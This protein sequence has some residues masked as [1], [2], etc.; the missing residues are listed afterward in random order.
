[1]ESGETVGLWW[2]PGGV[3]VSLVAAFAE[4]DADVACG[5]GAREGPAVEGFE[6]GGLDEG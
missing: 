5:E 6:E 2:K 3:E 4:H 1:M